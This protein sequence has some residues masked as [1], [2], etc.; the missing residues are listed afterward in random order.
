M[1]K[2]RILKQTK[3]NIK[4]E[5][6]DYLLNLAVKYSHTLSV[7]GV[8]QTI[9][10][11]PTIITQIIEVEQ[12]KKISRSLKIKIN[13]LSIDCWFINEVGEVGVRQRSFCRISNLKSV[14]CQQY[15]CVSVI[16]CIHEC[17]YVCVLVRVCVY[18]Y[19]CLVCVY[20]C[21]YVCECV[22]M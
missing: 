6:H 17:L 12:K 19:V 16:V 1:P 18:M 10:F 5:R 2:N 15:V 14:K 7:G 22:C 20:V 21:R 11:W 8:I 13:L 3:E 9:P 4:E